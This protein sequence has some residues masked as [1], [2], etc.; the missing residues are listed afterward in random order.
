MS[1]RETVKEL[2]DQIVKFQLYDDRWIDQLDR[3]KLH[4][5]CKGG[6]RV[7]MKASAHYQII[8]GRWS[9]LG[10]ALHGI[11]C[12]PIKQPWSPLIRHILG[13]DSG[14]RMEVE[15]AFE[16]ARLLCMAFLDEWEKEVQAEH[17]RY[18]REFVSHIKEQIE[19]EGKK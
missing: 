16:M 1:D 12:E 3:R 17:D 9:N 6:L 4:D 19:A 7:G 5:K 13:G 18:L 14:V 10:A 2:I 8:Q 15:K 11:L